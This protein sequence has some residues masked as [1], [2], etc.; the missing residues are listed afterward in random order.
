[1][2]KIVGVC[3]ITTIFVVVQI[4]AAMPEQCVQ[5]FKP[6]T[7][8]GV[9][10]G[11]E[12]GLDTI[13]PYPKPRKPGAALHPCKEFSLDPK[14]A[15]NQPRLRAFESHP[16]SPH[17]SPASRSRLDFEE[18]GQA[19]LCR[20]WYMA[21]DGDSLYNG[22]KTSIAYCPWPDFADS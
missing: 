16:L 20:W 19:V 8:L 7:R 6:A 12:G 10:P 9:T 5:A 15:T 2:N 14:A 17:Q 13:A 21:G 4:N 1:M 22:V 3:I 18:K 11:A